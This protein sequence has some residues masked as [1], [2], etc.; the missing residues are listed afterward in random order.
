MSKDLK[1]SQLES[2]KR[3][4]EE[5]EQLHQRVIALENVVRGMNAFFNQGDSQ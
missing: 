3:M 1:Q 5:N 4:K 2:L